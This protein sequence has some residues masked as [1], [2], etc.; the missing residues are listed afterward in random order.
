MDLIE[1]PAVTA[2]LDELLALAPEARL[3]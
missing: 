3:T 2:R 1:V